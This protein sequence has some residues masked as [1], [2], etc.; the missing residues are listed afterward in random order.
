VGLVLYLSM[1]ATVFFAILYLP[2]LERRF[3]LVLLAAL[4]VAML[5]LTWEDQKPAWFSLAALI[6]LA[7]ARMGGVS[8]AARQPTLRRAAPVASP[9]VAARSMQRPPFPGRNL[10]RDSS[11]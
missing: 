4:C 11:A 7:S 3:A 1:L 8:R 5:P 6:G 9:P 10:G 2:R